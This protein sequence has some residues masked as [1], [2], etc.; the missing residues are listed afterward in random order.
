ML[1][2]CDSHNKISQGLTLS[3][4]DDAICVS[5]NCYVPG[6]TFRNQPE[7]IPVATVTYGRLMDGVNSTFRYHFSPIYKRKITNTSVRNS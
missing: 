4:S 3:W 6:A 1:K 2:Y 7:V 5:K